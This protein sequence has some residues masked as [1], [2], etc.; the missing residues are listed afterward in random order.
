MGVRSFRPTSAGLR[1]RTVPDFSEI[2]KS[3]PEKSL[4]KPLSKTA[5]RNTHGR[6]TTRHIGGGHKRRFRQIDFRRDKIGVPSTVVSIEYD[7]NRSAYIA[8][9]HYAD[10]DK[11]YILAPIGLK[12]GQ[13]VL[14][15]KTADILPGNSLPMDN[16]PIGTFIHNIEM[17]P[18]KGG[19]LARSA[20]T[21]AQLMA[22]EGGYAFVKMPSGEL[23]K[24]L[25]NCRATIGQVGN[26]QHENIVIGKA[27]RSR[28][29]G[30]RPTVRGTAMNPV[31]H[32]MGGGEGRGK[33]NHPQSPWGQKS[34]GFKTRHNKRTDAMIVSRRK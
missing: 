1:F 8:L 33:G 17:R 27:G 23:R 5:G 9:L 25:S 13:V 29:L 31:D 26:E 21:Y 10:G 11:K 19:Q 18:G 14:S 6:I 16:I 20:G 34:K 12:V 7:P 22:R 3:K 4:T 28:W 24:V 15:D 32:P 2:T 30:I